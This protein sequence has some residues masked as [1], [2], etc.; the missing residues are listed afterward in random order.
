MIAWDYAYYS[1]YVAEYRI[2]KDSGMLKLYEDGL[3]KAQAKLDAG[4]C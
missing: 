3:K 4:D 1:K 2:R